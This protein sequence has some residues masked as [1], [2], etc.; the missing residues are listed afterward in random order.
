[1]LGSGGQGRCSGGVQ[2]ARRGKATPARRLVDKHRLCLV[3]IKLGW[4]RVAGEGGGAG[5]GGG[6]AF[7]RDSL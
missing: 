1:M 6:Q 3:N 2:L 5:G 7:G 4:M